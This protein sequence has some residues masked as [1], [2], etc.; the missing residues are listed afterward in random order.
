M[1][2]AQKRKY[3]LVSLLM[4]GTTDSDCCRA[5][6]RCPIQANPVQFLSSWERALPAACN[7]YILLKLD[8]NLLLGALIPCVNPKCS[9]LAHDVICQLP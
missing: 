7:L 6:Y 9:C 8:S 5:R 1:I 3:I 4:V 2:R